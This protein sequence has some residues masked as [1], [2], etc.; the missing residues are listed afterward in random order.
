MIR[1]IHQSIF[2]K[3]TALIVSIA[4]L[5]MSFHSRE[6]GE[7]VLN[8]GTMVALET[9]SV[10]KSNSV[11]IGQIIDFRVPYDVKVDNKVVIAA[12]SMARGQVMSAQRA[13]GIGQAGF[14][15]VQIRSVTAVDGQEI[16]LTGGNLNQEGEDKQTLAIVLGVFVCVLFLTIKGKD[17]QVPPGYHV[18]SAVA[19]TTTI[20][21]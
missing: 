5:C 1:A 16:L 10:I 6:N 7:T 17:A 3:P 9:I 4:F 2:T 14:V 15:E 20:K 13:K 18:R 11:L 12:G 19:M 8:A 21:T